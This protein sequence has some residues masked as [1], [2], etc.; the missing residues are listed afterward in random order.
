HLLFADYADW[1]ETT[2]QDLFCRFPARRSLLAPTPARRARVAR[3]GLRFAD[4]LARGRIKSLQG[5]YIQHI[6]SGY[7]STRASLVN[8]DSDAFRERV[9]APGLVV[10]QGPLVRDNTSFRKH[11][12]TVRHYFRPRADDAE[13]VAQLISRIRDRV[14]V[15]IGVHIRH[16]DYGQFMHGRYF[17]TIEQYAAAVERVRALWGTKR[18]GVL[19]CSNAQ[20]PVDRFRQPAFASNGSVIQDVYALAACDYI[21]GPPSTFS[22]WAS[23]YGRVPRYGFTDIHARPTLDD[24]RVVEV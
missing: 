13:R 1:F 8:L 11:A 19:I 16:G 14:D 9:R 7:E 12:D 15:L 10:F 17:F 6:E 21:V 2:A 5:K 18:T 3:W 22:Q 20:Q 4:S 24:F 23:F